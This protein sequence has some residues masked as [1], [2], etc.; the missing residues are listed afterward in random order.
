MRVS[1]T[2]WNVA[3]M[4]VVMAVYA[5]GVFMFV[6]RYASNA[7]DQELRYDAQWASA[8]ADKQADGSLHWFDDEANFGEDSP[9]LRV[10]C[11]D[12][13]GCGAE[14]TDGV[15]RTAKADRNP[16]PDTDALA[17]RPD[18]RIVS[19]LRQG[20]A[21]R[22][23]TTP[24]TLYGK[25][26]VIQVA[27]SETPMRRELMRLLAILLLGLPI[28]VAAAGI[29]G[30]SLARRALAPL[31]DMTERA[32]SITAANLHDRLPVANP[33]N[34]LGRLASVFNE[35][36]GRLEASFDQMRR[37]TA[38]VSHELRTPLTAMRS[39]GEV[40]LRERRD[41]KTYRGIIG[42][43]LEE[44]D[45]L[46][47]LVD[48]LLT[49]SR[50]ESGQTKLAQE[51]IDLHELAREVT[52]YLGVLA[53]EK[54]Q[55]LTVEQVG[56]PRGL[57]DRL[58]LR[59]ALVNLVDNAVK[60]SPVGGEIRVRVA[61]S[62]AGA[63]IDVTDSGPGVPPELRTRIFDR[64]DRGAQLRSGEAGG[65]GLGL[66][67]SKWALEVNGGRLTLE[68]PDGSGGVGST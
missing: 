16:I 37:F 35:T 58:V 62:S 19:I 38:D 59:Q 68:S 15:Y 67:I 14:F 5:A 39:V 27:R 2:L 42:S 33:S 45:R 23:L 36:L 57:G 13:N 6:G 28:G 41:E 50:A 1:L 65:T 44:V 64:Y 55:P 61:E 22:V 10:W 25:P 20:T 46:A 60:Y 40:G 3:A 29:F 21:Y 47:S 52:T 26:V 66:S 12:A 54:R 34:E 7:L 43:M 63:T 8:M 11:R 24:A 51:V 30:Y 53:E 17:A 18:S 56:S 49:W 31:E 48:R 9:W 32:Q 4:I